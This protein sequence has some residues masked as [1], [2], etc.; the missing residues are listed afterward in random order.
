ML[1]NEL[2]GEA[3]LR[4][5]DVDLVVAIEFEGLAKLSA[6]LA[7]QTGRPQSLDDLYQGLL[8]FQPNV[9]ALALLTLSVHPE[10]PE[11]AAAL[12]AKA[13]GRLTAA[14]EPAWRAAIETALAGHIDAGRRLRGEKTLAEEAADA[15]AAVSKKKSSRSTRSKAT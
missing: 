13:V 9:V 8:G 14:D 3:P 11:K 5:G 4:I 10:G 15:L 6:A 1:A 7:R 2:R 12:G